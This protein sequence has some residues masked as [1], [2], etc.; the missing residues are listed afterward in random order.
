MSVMSFLS[1]SQK[2]DDDEPRRYYL[3]ASSALQHSNA[4]LTNF[5]KRSRSS[6]KFVGLKNPPFLL[7]S[8]TLAARIA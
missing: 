2:K 7:G 8:Q 3:H 5:A 1:K 6:D 4:F